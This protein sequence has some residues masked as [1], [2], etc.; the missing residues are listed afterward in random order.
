MPLPRPPHRHIRR[1]QNADGVPS[2][3]LRE[4]GQGEGRNSLPRVRG[5]P[6]SAITDRN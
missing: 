4:E 2:P 6:Q 3:R 5:D 1:L